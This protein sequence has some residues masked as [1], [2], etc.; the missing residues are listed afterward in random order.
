MRE[1]EICAEGFPCQ[2]YQIISFFCYHFSP[3]AELFQKAYD[4]LINVLDQALW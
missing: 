3:T 2:I 1:Q 4:D